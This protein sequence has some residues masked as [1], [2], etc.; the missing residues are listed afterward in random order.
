MYTLYMYIYMCICLYVHT[1]PFNAVPYWLWESVFCICFDEF[2]PKHLRINTQ[3]VFFPMLCSCN[4]FNI[5]RTRLCIN[6]LIKVTYC[7][8]C[9]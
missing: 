5:K 4:T 2:F 9:L 7:V 1:L 3:K 8:L 6:K